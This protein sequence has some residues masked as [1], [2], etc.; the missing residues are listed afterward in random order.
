MANSESEDEISFEASYFDKAPSKDC[1]KVNYLQYCKARGNAKRKVGITHKF[2]PGKKT[3]YGNKDLLRLLDEKSIFAIAKNRE[4]ARKI[5]VTM[6]EIM[7]EKGEFLET[8]D[9]G[10]GFT[11]ADE[12]R[13][14][15]VYLTTAK[16]EEDKCPVCEEVYVETIRERT[17]HIKN[18]HFMY[19]LKMKH[20]KDE[21]EKKKIQTE[22]SKESRL[23]I[24]SFFDWIGVE[25]KLGITESANASSESEEEEE[26]PQKR[27]TRRLPSS[28][29]EKLGKSSSSSSEDEIKRP[30]VIKTRRISSSSDSSPPPPPPLPK[31]KKKQAKRASAGSLPVKK[32]SSS[33]LFQSLDKF[34]K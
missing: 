14:I 13:D 32:K 30:R 28:S 25:T 27:K 24:K 22:R 33:D 5:E 3:R 1:L 26:P 31:K 16:G 2:G 19:Y 20:Y 8:N 6:M 23:L 9:T 12:D 17:R 29:D 34:M 18:R 15:Y 21:Y 7:S 4:I 11:S 10:P